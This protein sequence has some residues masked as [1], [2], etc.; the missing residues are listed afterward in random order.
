MVKHLDLGKFTVTY[1]TNNRNCFGLGFEFYT[2]CDTWYEEE[3]G[4][5]DEPVARI[6]RLDL[7]FGFINL[8]YWIDS[9]EAEPVDFS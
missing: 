5:F 4:L 1:G 9:V 6:I 7:L 8:T 2:E 3:V